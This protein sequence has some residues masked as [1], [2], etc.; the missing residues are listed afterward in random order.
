VKSRSWSKKS[1]D[2]AT[3]FLPSLHCFQ[4]WLTPVSV[5]ACSIN[6]FLSFSLFDSTTYPAPTA[7]DTLLYSTI[8]LDSGTDMQAQARP[9]A[10][11]RPSRP[12]MPLLPAAQA[13]MAIYQL[14]LIPTKA[15][16]RWTFGRDTVVRKLGRYILNRDLDCARVDMAHLAGRSSPYH[17]R[18]Q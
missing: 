16:L 3:P 15:F 2:Y 10:R 6:T 14:P 4:V 8:F 7:I 1:E 5:V 11:S 13:R 18:R 12:T 9:N 17:L